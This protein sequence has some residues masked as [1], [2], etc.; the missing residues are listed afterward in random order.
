MPA[1]PD[2]SITLGP[3]DAAIILREDGSLEASLPDME[4]DNVTENVITGAALIFA[5]RDPEMFDLIHENF[6]K[7]C[8]K[9]NVSGANDD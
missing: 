6:I 4:A 1:E 3:L 5:L 8:M 9:N 2:K 7:E